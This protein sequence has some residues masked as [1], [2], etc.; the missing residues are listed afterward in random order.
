MSLVRAYTH[1][2][3]LYTAFTGSTQVLGNGD[4]LIDWANVPE[5]TEY[6]SS[7]GDAKMDL[8]LS[9]WSYRGYR[10]AW[11]G[12]PTQPPALAVQRTITGTSPGTDVSVSWNGSIEVAAWQI[13]G[14]SD[15]S[16]LAP[17]GKPIPKSGFETE[18][19]M[20]G[21]YATLELQAL[22]SSGAVLATSSPISG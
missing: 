22:N 14:G 6:D 17:I 9:S 16:H 19:S 15:A 2:P 10:F 3:S 4:A 13:L 12:K 5:I 11:D 21:Q 8:S 1:N 7:G 18:M 20:T